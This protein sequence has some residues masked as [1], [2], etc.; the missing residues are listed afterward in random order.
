MA[1]KKNTKKVHSKNTIRPDTKNIFIAC[2]FIVLWA[3]S[4]FSEL[5]S[6]AGFYVYKVLDYLLTP[7]LLSN[8]PELG[9]I[10]TSDFGINYYSKD[11]N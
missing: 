4:L 9:L 5:D 7:E 1:K 2:L 6:T 3:I 8:I 11:K 10:P